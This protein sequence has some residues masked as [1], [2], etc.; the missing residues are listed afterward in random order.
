[1]NNQGYNEIIIY[2]DKDGLAKVDVKIE[3]DS[4]WLTQLQ[5]AELFYC[6]V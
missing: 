6:V 1:M 3:N 4:L 2:Q 5:I